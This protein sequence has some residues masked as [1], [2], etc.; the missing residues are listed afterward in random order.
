M[1]KN[2]IWDF[3]GTLFDTYP[4][5]TQAFVSAL[6]G[7]SH[8]VDETDVLHLARIGLGQCTT[9]LATRYH[10]SQEDVGK[11]FQAHYSQIDLE[12]Q[13]LMPGAL[14]VCKFIASSGGVNVIVTHRG[15]KSTLALLRAHD[16]R[17]LFQD[18]ITA[19]DGFPKKPDPAGIEAI[20]QR[21]GLVKDYSL[22]VGDRELDV[23]AGSAAGVRTCIFGENDQSIVANYHVSIL[24]ELYEIVLTENVD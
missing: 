12:K 22:V 19:D 11:A 13:V 3:D 23:E 2:L 20:I 4:A 9:E 7:Y 15:R 5:F 6:A 17:D 8:S 1:I 14:D 18:L 16:V 24:Q 21:N 10:L